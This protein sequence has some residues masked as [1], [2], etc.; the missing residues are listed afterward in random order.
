MNAK[1]VF[2]AAVLIAVIFASGVFAGQFVEF[3]LKDVSTTTEAG[4]ATTTA[5]SNTVTVT[6]IVTTKTVTT[7]PGAK[8]GTLTPTE[9]FKQ[10]EGS[11]ISVSIT[12][13]GGGGAQGSGFVYDDKGH[14]VTNNHV[15]E[16]AQTIVV[17][18]LNGTSAEATLVGRDVY[19][20]LAV[21]KVA[22]PSKTLKPIPL[23][24][25]GTLEV[26]EQVVAIGNPFGLGGSMT[27]GIVSQLGRS[28]TSVG[29]YLMIDL[30]QTDAAVN[31]GNSG[32]PL[33]NMKGEVVGVNTLILS[34]SGGSEG[35]GLAIPSHSIK[36]VA[37]SL[38]KTGS[39]KHP[40]VG[41]QGTDVTPAIAKA[42]SLPESRGFLIMQVVN[43]SPAEKAGLKGGDRQVTIEGQSVTIGGDVILGV[44]NT[45]ARKLDD[46]LLYN[47]R[48]KNPGDTIS[49]KIF[50][51]GKILTI[52]LVLGERPPPQE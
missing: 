10:V 4:N 45:D 28:T 20:D 33:L 29:G 42:M 5:T 19:S 49:I 38:I 32:G 52:D 27:L 11:V 21:I 40:Y 26:G 12:I 30:I 23:G 31:P 22:S 7:T 6:T 47:E 41:V 36:R 46:I 51:A 1:N 39:Y 15:V 13:A 24:D 43:G 2:V 44:D 3:R 34:Q 9:L 48:F 14:M 17:T 8:L 35:V 37:D 18:F 25:S 16:D 50:R